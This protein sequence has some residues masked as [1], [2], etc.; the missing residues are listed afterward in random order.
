MP[1]SD[2]RVWARGKTAD[3]VL[4][5]AGQL[6]QSLQHVVTNGQPPQAPIRNE[7]PANQNGFTEGEY[8]KGEDLNRM[9]PAIV[10]AR[11]D[12]RVAGINEQLAS[13]ALSTIKSE[14]ASDFANYGPEIYGH[15]SR[16]N[17]SAGAWTVDNL[18]YVVKMVR[19]DHVEEIVSARLRDAST[20]QEP[21]L[22]STGAAPVSPAP[23]ATDFSV[24]SAQLPPEFREKLAKAGITDATMQEFCRVNNMTVQ[25]YFT[26][27]TRGHVI[28]EAPVRA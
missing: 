11:V 26:M 14:Y 12:S 13:I 18:R 5:I 27:V 15:L 1:D 16:L 25:D 22:R 10:D 6:E 28:T 3:E 17:K 23:L 20:S 4:N 19:A 2:P 8:V 7:A 21:A 9:A 24:Q